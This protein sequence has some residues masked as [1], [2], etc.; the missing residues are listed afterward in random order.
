MTG[1]RRSLSLTQS[2]MLI[3]F[4]MLVVMLVFESVK[5]LFAPAITIW[6]SH[7]A[8]ILF[9]SVVT[10]I[11][12]YFPLRYAFREREKAESAEA[13]LREREELFRGVAERSSDIIMV[14]DLKGKAVYVSP[15]VRRVLGYD[16]KTILGK[17][18][19]DFIHPDDMAEVTRGIG[20]NLAGE[21]SENLE[22]RIQ[23]S[24]GEFAVI[25]IAGS[26]VVKNGRIVGVQV[27]G[28]DITE[29]RNAQERIRNLL[30][31]LEEQLRIINTSPAV[32]FLWKAEENWPVET[33]SENVRHFG[34]TPDDFLSGKVQYSSIVHPEDLPRVASEVEYNSSHS[35]DEFVQTYRILGKEKE[36]YWIDNYTHIRRDETGRITH[37]EGI[38][39]DITTR[40]HVEEALKESELRFHELFNSMSSGVA[41]Y[42]AVDDGADFVVIDFNH[43]AEVIDNISREKIIGRRIS[44]VFPGVRKFGLMEVFRRVWQTG[45][46]EHFPVSVYKDERITGWRENYVYRLP[47]GEIVAIYDDI[48]ARK[49]AEEALRESEQKFRE[50]FDNANDAIEIVEIDANGYPGRFMDMNAVACRMLHYSKEELLGISPLDIDTRNFSQPFDEIIREMNTAGHVTFQTEHRTKE[51]IIFPVEINA[52]LFKLLGRKTLLSVVRD[53]TERKQVEDALRASEQRSAKLLEALPDMMFVISREGEYRDFSVAEASDLAVPPDRIIGTNVRDSGFGEKTTDTILHHVNLALETKK[54]QQFEYELTLPRGTRQY[55]ARMVAL[56]EEEVLG[57]VRDITE[58]KEAEIALRV[59]ENR[60]RILFNESPIPLWEEDFS[61]LKEWMDAKRKEGIS[62]FSAYFKAYPRD[63]LACAMQVRVI[64]LNH[65]A[66]TLFRAASFQEF[67]KGLSTIFPPESHDAF[68]MELTE[69]YQ[70][71]REFETEVPLRTLQGEE[72]IVIMKV[73][74]VPGSEET[75]SRVLVSVLDITQRKQIEEA[76]HQ[77]NKKLNMLSSI[78]R[79]D[80]LNLI[81]AIRGYLELSLDIVGDPELR[82]YMEKENEAVNAIQRQ[83]EFTRYYQD[84]GVEEP[85]WQDVGELVARV[86]EQLDLTGISLENLLPG[87]EVFADPLIEKVFYNLIENSLRH[88]EHVTAIRFSSSETDSGMV[89]SYRDNGIGISEEDKKKLF[90][91]GFGKHTGLGLFLSREI[92]SITGIRIRENGESGKGV[93]FEILVPEGRYR[94]I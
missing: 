62:D 24:D 43:G 23:R 63:L 28:R 57:I 88:G 50:I 13:A 51:G 70:G 81:M 82:K 38:I 65:A 85:K 34:Y 67:Q 15:S 79:H 1:N 60:Y 16:P 3:F 10:I 19:A 30:R 56:T 45:D 58:E 49:E 47:S 87:L 41:V 21:I 37:Y 29:K 90:Q 14:T 44:E 27:I 53:I 12:V 64:D 39:L 91:R 55:E 93:N 2:F 84:I 86:A 61:A 20:K 40:A 9:T 11:I 69:L 17:M 48:T 32:A 35:I 54:L 83:I 72:L 73:T 75:M 71:R 66:M 6:Q 52:H 5:Q 77:A 80:I 8:T 76:L 22:V 7:V 94:V 59:S 26:P 46:S 42:R 33:V 18:P 36:E 74:I 89:I 31:I 68:C 25:D 78:T 92:L 4:T